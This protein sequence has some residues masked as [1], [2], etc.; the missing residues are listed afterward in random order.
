LRKQLNKL[1]DLYSDV[2]EQPMD[3]G[4]IT[5]RVKNNHYRDIPGLFAT[6]KLFLL[7]IVAL[8]FYENRFVVAQD[9]N[10]VF[11][12]CQLFNESPENPYHI[13]SKE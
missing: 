13:L 6:V 2:I 4:T 8:E 11:G 3:F 10:L 12:N 7:F 9:M 1:F 5:E